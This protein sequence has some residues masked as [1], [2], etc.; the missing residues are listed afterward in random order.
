MSLDMINYNDFP[1]QICLFSLQNN[2]I[3]KRINLKTK[4]H[5]PVALRPV[6]KWA[7]GEQIPSESP[8]ETAFF[9]GASITPH[10]IKRGA[11][12]FLFQNRILL[13]FPLRMDLLPTFQPR[14]WIDISELLRNRG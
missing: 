7:T 2:I 5:Q 6:A 9:F 13:I 4:L 11:A 8:G 3:W 14:Y 12:W 1:F 10:A